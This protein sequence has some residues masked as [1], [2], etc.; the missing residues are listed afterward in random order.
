MSLPE[1][2]QNVNTYLFTGSVYF[3]NNFCLQKIANSGK[4]KQIRIFYYLQ[5]YKL[6]WY[7][8]CTYYISAQEKRGL[9]APLAFRIPTASILFLGIP[10]AEAH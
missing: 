9:S 10:S 7:H 8:T 4:I 6:A 1:N 5:T 3:V 2:Y